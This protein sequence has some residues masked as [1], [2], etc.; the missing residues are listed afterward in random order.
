MNKNQIIS[1]EFPYESRYV[2]VN[3]FKIHY[4]E[5]GTGDPPVVL[6]HGIP[7][8]A[9]LWR[10]VIPHISPYGRT[11]SIDLIGSGKSD[12]PLDIDYN[13]ETY[14]KFLKGTFEALNLNNIILVCMDLGLIAGL[15]YAMHN[16]SNISGI[17]MFEG[18]FMPADMTFRQMPF[19][20]RMIMRLLRIKKIAEY[21]IVSKG[22]QAI[23]DM[24]TM[25]MV[26][27]PSQKEIEIYQAPWRDPSVRKK[28]WLEG[29]GPN[30][31]TPLSVRPGDVTDVINSY[32]SLLR[33][34]PVPK[35]LLYGEPG[36]A[37]RKNGVVMAEKYFDSLQVKYAGKGK[38][39][40]PE[41]EPENTGHAIGDFYR[42]LSE[43]K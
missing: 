36:S 22:E 14:T 9:Y 10:N 39:F 24:L 17:V 43:K 8:H 11:V 2:T 33:H 32:S 35:L 23:R 30:T 21:A 37:I 16:E 12:K 1:S 31:I 40:L 34:S 4:V 18:F 25:G 15:N 20:A 38:H 6:L 5:E 29:T 42:F 3:N 19:S 41:D 27:K 7:V 26:R 13:P 28:V